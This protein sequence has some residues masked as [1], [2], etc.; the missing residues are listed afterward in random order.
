[1]YVHGDECAQREVL[2]LTQVALHQICQV[3]QVSSAALQECLQTM[4]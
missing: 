4:P 3:H 1:M 2:C